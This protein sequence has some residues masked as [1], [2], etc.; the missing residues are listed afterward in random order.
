MHVQLF[1]I[2][3]DMN[4]ML[5]CPATEIIQSF[6]LP[7]SGTKLHKKNNFRNYAHTLTKPSSTDANRGPTL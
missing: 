1:S 4:S 7:F 6:K 2:M 3:K 5:I